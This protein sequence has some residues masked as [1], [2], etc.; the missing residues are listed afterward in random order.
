MEEEYRYWLNLSSTTNRSVSVILSALS[1][2]VKSY[3]DIASAALKDVPEIL[4]NVDVQLSKL[5]KDRALIKAAFTEDRARRIFALFDEQCVSVL[6]SSAEKDKIWTADS[7]EAEEFLTDCLAICNKWS[8]VCRALTE[9]LWPEDE[10][11]RWTSGLVK[12]ESTEK[13]R[14]RLDQIRTIKAT[15][16]EV[17]DLLGSTLDKPHPS[18]VFMK[19]DNLN[20]GKGGDEVWTAAFRNFD[21]KMSRYDDVIAERLKKKFYNPTA[22]SRQ[23]C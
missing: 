9:E 12:A 16:E 5:W 19:I 11:N 8:D 2:L 14:Q 13:L 6:Q 15:V 21:Q 1:D 3:N 20:V 18:E 7:S 23:V 4:E 17:A 22:D 10:R